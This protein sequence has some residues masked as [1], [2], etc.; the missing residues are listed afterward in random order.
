MFI[1]LFMFAWPALFALSPYNSSKSLSNQAWWAVGIVFTLLIGFRYQIGVD[2]EAYLTMYYAALDQPFSKAIVTSDP[3]YAFLNWVSGLFGGEIYLV[4]L[5]CGA[6]IMAGIISFSRRQSQPWLAFVVSVPY[7]IIVASMG[8]SRQGVALGFELLALVAIADGRLWRFFLFVLLGALFHK[9]AVILLPFGFISIAS[10]N[11]LWERLL[12][13]GIGVWVGLM[14]VTEYYDSMMLNYVEAQLQSSGSQIR[15]IM[16]ALPAVLLLLFQKK[17]MPDDKDERRFWM[18]LSVLA[19]ATVPLVG[20][21]STAVDRIAL[22]FMPMQ[23][24]VY[25]RLNLQFRQLTFVVALGVVIVYG[26]VL[27]IWLNYGNYTYAWV[28]YKLWPFI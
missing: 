15:V 20:F 24:Y 12:V 16:N 3:G 13:A 10:H 28:P 4:N 2:W 26:V 8:Y 27:W 23:L 21:A 6:V 14:L 11:R 18:L 7:M 25:S 17:L 22:Y 9:T 19:I 5:V 1:Y